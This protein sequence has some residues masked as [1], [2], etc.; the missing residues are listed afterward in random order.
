LLGTRTPCLFHLVFLLFGLF[1]FCPYSHVVD[2][3]IRGDIVNKY[4]RVLYCMLFGVIW[5]SRIHHP[6]LLFEPK[7]NYTVPVERIIKKGKKERKRRGGEKERKRKGE[8]EKKS[9]S[10]LIVYLEASL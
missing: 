8:K 4:S 9:T 2:A 5:P 3:D 7:G 1:S 10:A 6:S